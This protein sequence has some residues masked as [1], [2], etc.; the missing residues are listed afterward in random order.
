MK[1][2]VRT[3]MVL[4]RSHSSLGS[5]AP[6]RRGRARRGLA[7]LALALSSIVAGSVALGPGSPAQAACSFSTTLRAGARSEAVRCLQV[8]LT[9]RGFAPG[10]ADGW[11]GGMTRD[12]V[13]AYQRT[14]G[15]FVDGVVGP[16][17]AGSLGIWGTSTS[18]PTP[19]PPVT[20]PPAPAPTPTGCTIAVSV[21][22]GARGDAAR[23]AQSALARAGASPGPID[24]YFGAM[25]RAA[26]IAFQRSRGLYA[27]GVVGRQT[28]TALGI[29]G[30]TTSGSG[31]G[32]P[33]ANCTPPSSVPSSARQ[34]VVVTASGTSADVDLL[35][36]S[37]DTWT[38]AR[39]DMRGRV[40]RNGIRSLAARRA[41]DG[42]TPAGVFALGSM[43]AP[44]GQTFQF[45]GNGANPGVPGAWRQVRSGDCWDVTPGVATYNTLVNRTSANCTGDNEYLPD[46]QNAYSAAA[47]IGAN[48]GPDRSGDQPGE[49]PLAGAIFLHRHSYDA[50]GSSRPTAGCVSLTS[51]DLSAV[52][53]TLV[54]GEAWFVIR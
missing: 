27:D 11:F 53:R 4:D 28:A 39:V 24:G 50:T 25:S 47:L 13:I 43:T 22:L 15:L 16:R 23:C 29:W 41:G 18:A 48:M 14:N 54:P 45:F 20:P 35:V 40:G 26:A 17:T 52:L 46:Y 33:S 9:G 8:T 10:P 12:A 6:W 7:A 38:C 31:S 19:P 36:R 34:V 3:P 42:T 49:P 51:A 32:T 5:G 44:D 37:G 30:S 21:Q 2:V 1:M